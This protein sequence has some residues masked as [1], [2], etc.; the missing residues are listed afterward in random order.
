MSL[1]SDALKIL[2]NAYGWV[3]VVIVL[4]YWVYWP[5]WETKVQSWIG[6]FNEQLEDIREKQ[7]ALTQVVRALARTNADS[8]LH[9]DPDKVDNHFVN[10]DVE[11]NDFI[12]VKGVETEDDDDKRGYQ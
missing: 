9:I 5:I 8:Q 6:G 11:P 2:T 12:V 1:V 7:V 3:I 10:D 4:A